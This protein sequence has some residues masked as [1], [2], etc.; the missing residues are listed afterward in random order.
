MHSPNRSQNRITILSTAPVSLLLL[1]FHGFLSVKFSCPCSFLW[2]QS[3]LFLIFFVPAFFAWLMM[4]LFLKFE[5]NNRTGSEGQENRRVSW[6]EK[7]LYCMIR[8]IPSLIWFCIFLIDGDYF[9]CAFT[10][11]EG[12]Y[13]CDKIHPNCVSWC[14]SDQNGTN[15]SEYKKTRRLINVSKVN[16]KYFTPFYTSSKFCQGKI[17]GIENSMLGKFE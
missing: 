15:E 13:F 11:N 10:F 7:R 16:T 1:G 12:K 17:N 6:T 14:K 9:A 5:E 8:F 3:I 4:Q 2:N